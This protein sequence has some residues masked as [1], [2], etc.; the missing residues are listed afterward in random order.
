MLQ[1]LRR[2]DSPERHLVHETFICTFRYF[3][4]FLLVPPVVSVFKGAIFVF[5]PRKY[6]S[7]IQGGKVS[8]THLD[9]AEA[10]AGFASSVLPLLQPAPP[11]PA[12]PRWPCVHRLW[13]AGN[14]SL[15]VRIRRLGFSAAATGKLKAAG[16]EDPA[17]FSL[18][19]VRCG[20]A[21][22]ADEQA[23]DRERPRQQT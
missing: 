16:L 4:V 10:A 15:C 21:W 2:Q 19:C 18:A 5:L 1:P 8:A 22:A 3:C 7:E 9:E 11:F 14:Y 20:C 12:P 23:A 6:Y 13:C 17:A